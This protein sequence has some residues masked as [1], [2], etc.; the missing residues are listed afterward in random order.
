MLAER[1]REFELYYDE[2]VQVSNIDKNLDLKINNEFRNKCLILISLI[3]FLAMVTMVR[4]EMVVNNGYELVQLK[5]QV[6]KLDQDNER[7][8]LDIAKLKSPERIQTIA[9][10]KLG[11][12]IPQNVYFVNTNS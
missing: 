11:M 10:G 8:K 12:T 9:V 6:N 7:L 5:G 1:K 2:E 4:S 3:L